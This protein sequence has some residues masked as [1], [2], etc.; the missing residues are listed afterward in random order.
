LAGVAIVT[1]PAAMAYTTTETGF[2][3]LIIVAVLAV[4]LLT[5][6]AQDFNAPDLVR[7]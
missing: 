6:R 4:Y 1:S 3:T 5:R 7:Q 2:V